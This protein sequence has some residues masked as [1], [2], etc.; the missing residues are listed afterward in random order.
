MKI[1]ISKSQWNAIGKKAGWV[2]T[3]NKIREYELMPAS[4]PKKRQYIRRLEDYKAFHDGDEP[5]EE[6]KLEIIDVIENPRSGRNNPQNTKKRK[7]DFSGFGGGAGEVAPLKD[8]SGKN[9]DL[10]RFDSKDDKLYKALEKSS[11]LPKN[12]KK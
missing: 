12:F 6:R 2:K 7:R 5:D 9:V 11:P 1:K 10:S 8:Q 4:E 3:A